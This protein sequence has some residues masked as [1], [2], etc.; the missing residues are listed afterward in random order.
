MILE[1]LEAR[2]LAR[3]SE[4]GVSIPMHPVVRSI[5]LVFLAKILRP[6]SKEIGFELSPATDRI[7]LVEALQELLSLPAAPSSGRVISSDLETVG[8]DLG[9]VPMDEVLGF[10]QEHLREHRAYARAVRRFVRDLSLTTIEE[11][12]EIMED[13][14]AEIEDMARDL[15][16][17]SRNAWK[18]PASFALGITGAAWTVVTGDPFAA[19]IGV[20]TA[21]LGAMSTQEPEIGAY[22]YIFSAA[23]RY[24]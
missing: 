2:G 20:G 23:Q 14:Q 21:A 24:A 17:A 16:R 22:S 19:L 11:Q 1:E 18:R 3:K 15:K 13:R 8:I 10:R 12:V 9:P 4:D 5:V 7:Q 6:H